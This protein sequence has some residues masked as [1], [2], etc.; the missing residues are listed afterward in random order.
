MHHRLKPIPGHS[1]EAQLRGAS[2]RKVSTMLSNELECCCCIKLLG[3]HVL[4]EASFQHIGDQKQE[5]VV[6]HACREHS[7]AV[8]HA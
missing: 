5:C 7:L 8:H 6:A 1:S 2:E 4:G 3:R